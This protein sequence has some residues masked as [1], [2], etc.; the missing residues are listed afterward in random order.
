MVRAE[1]CGVCG[2]CGV[3]GGGGVGARTDVE[4]EVF[5][6]V[7]LRGGLATV[8]L[9]PALAPAPFPPWLA[10]GTYFVFA[11]WFIA[12]AQVKANGPVVGARS[13]IRLSNVVARG[14]SSGDACP[15]RAHKLASLPARS[16]VHTCGCADRLRTGLPPAGRCSPA[17]PCVAG[18]GRAALNGPRAFCPR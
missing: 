9:L 7:L 1:S 17:R 16:T 4:V 13:A 18:G 2:V 11:S 5:V 8:P 6:W 12:A 14:R 3:W 15:V 10:R